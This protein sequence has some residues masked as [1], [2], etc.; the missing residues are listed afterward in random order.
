MLEAW[1]MA[2]T[3]HKEVESFEGE[4]K[5]DGL[6]WSI[7]FLFFVSRNMSEVGSG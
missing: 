6:R 3:Y 1:E 2:L 4:R 5:R 7:A